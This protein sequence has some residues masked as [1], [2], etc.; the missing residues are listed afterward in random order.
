MKNWTLQK[1]GL[2]LGLAMLPLVGGCDL[3]EANSAPAPD[4]IPGQQPVEQSIDAAALE[5]NPPV[6][7]VAQDQL[8]DAPGKV[9]ST[10]GTAKTSDNP[11]LSE[12]VKL[13]QA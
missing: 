12:V 6:P 1:L 10:P 4:A 2:A 9:I 13:A 7:E 3:Q 5:T 8:T 11:Q